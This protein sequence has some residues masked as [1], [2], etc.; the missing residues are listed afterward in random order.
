MDINVDDMDAVSLVTW[1]V[2]D[3]SAVAWGLSAAD[4]FDVTE[5]LGGQSDLILMLVGMVGAYS[6]AVTYTD[7]GE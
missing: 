1:T 4:L 3:L 2:A 6:L 7:I 5:F